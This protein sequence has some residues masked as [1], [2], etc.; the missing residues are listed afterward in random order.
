MT[1]SAQWEDQYRIFLKWLAVQNF[2]ANAK[3]IAYFNMAGWNNA[4]DVPVEDMASC[5]IGTVMTILDC[6][7]DYPQYFDQDY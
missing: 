3:D 4:G 1:S 7:N 6:P 5:A 2:P